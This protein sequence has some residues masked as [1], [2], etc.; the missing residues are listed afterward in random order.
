[1]SK[2]L[3]IPSDHGGGRGHV[4]RCIYLANKLREKGHDSAIVLEEKHFKSSQKE[5]IR[6]FLLNTKKERIVKYQFKKPFKPAVQLNTRI[7]KYPVFVGF[8][9]LAYQVPRDGYLSPRLVNYRFNQLAKIVDEFKPDILVG[10]THFL[11][12]PLG[13]KFNLPVVQ[14]TRLAGYPPHPKFL[15]WERKKWTYTEPDALMPF[16]DL[17]DK[18]SFNGMSKAEDLLTGDRYVIPSSRKLEPVKDDENSVI[19][20]GALSE[21]HGPGKSIPLFDN[22]DE[23]PKIYVT[24]GG[25]AARANEKQFFESIISAFNK[26]EF[27]VLVSTGKR[28]KAAKYNR[29]SANIQFVD[30]APGTS[31]IRQSDLVIF[32]GGYGTAMEVVLSGKPSIVI[33]SHSE[34]EGNGRRLEKLGVSKTI[35]PI[36]RETPMDVLEY[37]WPYGDYQMLAGFDFKLD[38]QELLSSVR[39]LLGE[40][41]YAKAGKLSVDLKKHQAEADYDNIIKF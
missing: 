11:T 12:W 29:R 38:E 21:F 4:A 28:V 6:S 35:I 39:E 2:I 1:M 13:R 14:I 10:D 16:S 34:Q 9:S 31:A 15:W 27:D 36:A 17:M 3:F 8:G 41:I 23:Y 20:C 19:Y 5:N 24:I 40:D 18:L 25:G 26:T 33:P 37:S 30:W 7:T 32:H 22:K